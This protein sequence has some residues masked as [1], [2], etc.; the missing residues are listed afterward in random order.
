MF[1][2]IQLATS[3]WSSLSRTGR[4]LRKKKSKISHANSGFPTVRVHREVPSISFSDYR[5]KWLAQTGGLLPSIYATVESLQKTEVPS[6]RLPPPLPER[7]SQEVERKVETEI[8]PIQAI[9]S[10]KKEKEVVTTEDQAT[11]SASEDSVTRP[12]LPEHHSGETAH[13][14]SL[15][16]RCVTVAET[17]KDKEASATSAPNEK[18]EK[19]KPKKKA[20]TRAPA[21]P[22][23]PPPRSKA[24][25]SSSI[26]LAPSPSLKVHFCHSSK[27]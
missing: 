23:P 13:D 7:L 16:R 15:N 22:P 24:R 21:P 18:A 10:L 12:V 27:S 2:I 14:A 8:P 11:P 19:E 26:S 3:P 4:A 20:V 5:N 1:W 17:G 25:R 6:R 9:E